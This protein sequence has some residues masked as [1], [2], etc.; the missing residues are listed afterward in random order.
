M[1]SAP[2]TEVPWLLLASFMYAA[3]RDVD[4]TP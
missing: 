4:D 1:P 3:G 2:S